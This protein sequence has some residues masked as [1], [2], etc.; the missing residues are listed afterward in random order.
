MYLSVE[1]S[2]LRHSPTK[3]SGSVEIWDGSVATSFAGG[4]GTEEDPYLIEN[5]SDLLAFAS[6]IG[7][8]ALAGKHVKLTADVDLNQSV[9][10]G[11]AAP[12]GLTGR[13]QYLGSLCHKGAVV[14]PSHKQIGC[15]LHLV[16]VEKSFIVPGKSP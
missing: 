2:W 10:T 1:N 13:I 3:I 9:P 14:V 11:D 16:G 8:A 4:S 12:I 7:T 6:K 5:G 15:R